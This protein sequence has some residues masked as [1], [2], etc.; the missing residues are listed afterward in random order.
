MAKMKISVPHNLG[1]GE[2]ASRVRNLVSQ[3]KNQ[4]GSQITDMKETWNGNKGNFSFRAMGI[5]VDGEIFV[6][7]SQVNLEG[8]LPMAAL[9]FKGTIESTIRNKLES[10]LS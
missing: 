6:E 4:Y 5:N 9:P 10:L 1:E 2:A 3:L 7:P 8:N